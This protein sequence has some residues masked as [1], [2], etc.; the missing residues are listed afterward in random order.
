MAETLLS[1]KQIFYCGSNEVKRISHRTFIRNYS[2]EVS[3]IT[4]SRL[5]NFDIKQKN[6]M[7]Y[8]FYYI[9]PAPNK[10]N[11]SEC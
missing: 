10:I 6:G 8:L 5:N 1:H 4:L 7:K 9:P 11:V 3:N 2:P